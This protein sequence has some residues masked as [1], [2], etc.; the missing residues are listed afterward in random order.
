M[1]VMWFSKLCSGV[2]WYVKCKKCEYLGCI[3][4]GLYLFVLSINWKTYFWMKLSCELGELLM[5]SH[6]IASSRSAA[7]F[8]QNPLNVMLLV[9]WEVTFVSIS[10]DAGSHIS[11]Q[12]WVNKSLRYSIANACRSP[13]GFGA[14][15]SWPLL[16]LLGGNNVAYE[17]R[18]RSPLWVFT[19]GDHGG[20]RAPLPGPHFGAAAPAR[21]PWDFEFIFWQYRTAIC[22][23]Y[24]WPSWD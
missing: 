5:I 23:D 13:A 11:N 19:H 8:I 6:S 12:T 10:V 20:T 16:F 3:G 14:F 1:Y 18:T 17:S 9:H 2:T 22:G 4:V 15:I 7:L 24:L 21:E